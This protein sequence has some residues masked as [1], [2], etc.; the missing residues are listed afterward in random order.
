MNLVILFAD[1][2]HNELPP[3]PSALEAAL[4]LLGTATA[5]GLFVRVLLRG[6]GALG[7]GDSP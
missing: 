5:L 2:M 6:S 1:G 4:G 7:R 3:E